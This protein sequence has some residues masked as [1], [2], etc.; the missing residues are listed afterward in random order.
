MADTAG[1]SVY[2]LVGTHK[3][4]FVLVSDTARQKWDLQGPYFKGLDVHHA[5]LDT[6]DEPT[7]YVAVNNAWFGSS[8]HISR[9]LGETWQESETPIRF[10]EGG[11]RSLKRIWQ[12]T[13]GR[14]SEPGVVYAGVDPAA[15]FV[16]RDGGRSWQ[17][18]EALAQHPTRDRWHPGA[19]GLMVHS[20]CLHPTDS[21]KMWVGISAAGTFATEDGG[22][23]WEP[24]NK[25]VLADFSPEKYPEVGQCVH[26][27]TLHPGRPERLYQQNHCGV[28]RTDNE[29]RDWIDLSDGLPSRF[30]FP[31]VVHPQ[32][33]DTIYV[34]PEESPE[35]RCPVNGDFAVYR[36]R[37]AGNTWQRL[38]EGLPGPQAFLGVYRQAMA[39]DSLKPAGLYLGTSTGQVFVSTDDGDHWRLA[40]NWLPPVYSVETA[41]LQ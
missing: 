14:D 41:V 5:V 4:L 7:L 29:G 32:D 22:R 19:G 40:V 9:D 23:T 18:I 8:L 38:S 12:I 6:R 25:N 20:I 33:P 26:H 16:S 30:G 35:F 11:D 2:L 39:A 3:G 27:L 15:L 28:Y 21:R 31:L 34:V 24:R 10:P 17:E 13:P 1:R 36:S 37:D